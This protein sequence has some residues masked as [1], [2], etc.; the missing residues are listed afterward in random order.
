MTITSKDW[1]RIAE[2]IT[3]RGEEYDERKNWYICNTGAK[4][5]LDKDEIKEVLVQ[6]GIPSLIGRLWSDGPKGEKDYAL[7]DSK[8]QDIRAMF[9]LFIALDLED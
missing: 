5:G 3:L 6:Y 4:L 2:H 1:K 9:C 8:S 7:Y